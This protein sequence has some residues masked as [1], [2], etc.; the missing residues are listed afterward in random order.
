MK[1]FVFLVSVLLSILFHADGIS[2]SY[3]YMDNNHVALKFEM[4]QNVLQHYRINMDCPNDKM[5]NLC[6]AD[7]ILSNIGLKIDE[8]KVVFEFESSTIYN[9]HTILNF[10]S[11][12]KFHE[13]KMV[14]IKNNCFYD[15]NPKFKNR[16]RIY[17]MN[18][19]K[20]FLLTK[21][22]DSIYLK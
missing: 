11:K 4:D 10:T 2:E 13:V 19:E 9:G 12:N 17:I 3:F 22:K 18:F 1:P 21:V 20:S 14:Q 6:V 15:I 7:Y 16:V 8:N 5:L